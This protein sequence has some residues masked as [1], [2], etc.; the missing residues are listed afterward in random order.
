MS[1][2]AGPWKHDARSPKYEEF[3]AFS[4]ADWH[5]QRA[6]SYDWIVEG[7]F[8]RGTV[9]ILAGDGGL[10]KSLLCQ[11]LCTAAALGRQWL[12]L[13]TQRCRALALFCEDDRDELQRR[14][15]A[16]N[17]YY[18]CEMGELEDVMMLDR[19]GRDSVLMRFGRWGDEGHTTPAFE[20]IRLIAE[21]HG[22]QIIILDT[23]ADTFS[24]N[25]IDRNQPRTFVRALRRWAIERQGIVILT[26]HPSVQG[27]ADGSGRSG[28][29]GWRNSVRS[30]IYLTKP[31]KKGEEEPDPNARV[32]KTM[33]MNAGRS[34]GKHNLVWSKGVFV[35]LEETFEGYQ[36]ECPF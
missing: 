6:P 2:A 19:A 17:R 27:M 20:K 33:K 16:I 36:P 30:M 18:G 31:K 8:L 7:C 28:S 12:G 25:E 1:V 3:R 32:L 9:A 23:V 10:G 22:A 4:P 29:T 24:G 26:Q 13:G 34:D 15:E 35:R 11:Q 21:E 14:Q 5:G